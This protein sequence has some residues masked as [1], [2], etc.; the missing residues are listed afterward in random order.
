MAGTAQKTI[1]TIKRPR[2]RPRADSRLEEVLT[3]AAAMFSNRGYA[4]TT[5]EDIA[6]QIGM[7][8]PGLYYYAESKE[9]L[10]EKSY[11]WT[12]KQ[13]LDKLGLENAPGTGREL[14]TRFFLIYAE[15]VCDD[16]SRCFLSSENHYLTPEGRA[17]SDER[18]HEVNMMAAELLAK[19][20]DDGSLAKTD[21]RYTLLT[22]FG[23]F[24]ALAT[25]PK[26]KSSPRK[27]GEAIL[28]IL[29]GGLTPRC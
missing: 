11:N 2:G 14:L 16:G 9:D 19:G 12:H 13:F 17:R 5:L 26:S 18:V 4:A 24:N 29:L 10:L 21:V 20:V 25:A 23:A 1:V 28:E 3:T 27:M 7:T 6:A 8:R 15:A 22:L